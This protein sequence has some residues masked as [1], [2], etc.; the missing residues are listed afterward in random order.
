MYVYF[1]DIMTACEGKF[2]L[3]TWRLIDLLTL[4]AIHDRPDSNLRIDPR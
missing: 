2:H 3:G 1:H 4:K